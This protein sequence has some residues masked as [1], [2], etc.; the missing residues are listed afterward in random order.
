MR[1][2]SVLPATGVLLAASLV[3][4]LRAA[5]DKAEIAAAGWLEA[6]ITGL[7]PEQRS[8]LLSD[9]ADRFAGAPVAT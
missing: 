6:K 8:F 4:P 2:R 1:H 3:A 5:G 9:D 7:A